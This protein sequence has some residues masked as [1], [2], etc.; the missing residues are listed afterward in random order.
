MIVSG[1]KCKSLSDQ[2]GSGSGSRLY[3]RN[4]VVE[5]A[6][7]PGWRRGVPLSCGSYY[8]SWSY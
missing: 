4:D 1:S 5:M 8:P 2:R 3:D 7:W 6:H